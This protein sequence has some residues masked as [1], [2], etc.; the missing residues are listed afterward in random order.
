VMSDGSLSRVLLNVCSAKGRHTPQTGEP[1]RSQPRSCCPEHRGGRGAGPVRIEDGAVSRSCSDDAVGGR[2]RRPDRFCVR[3]RV[4]PE[5]PCTGSALPVPRVR[6]GLGGTAGAAP[7]T[8]RARR[9]PRSGRRTPGRA[10]RRSACAVWMHGEGASGPVPR[11]R[12]LVTAIIVRA[13]LAAASALPPAGQAAGAA[14]RPQGVRTTAPGPA[15][16]ASGRRSLRGGRSGGMARLRVAP[17]WP[18]RQALAVRGAARQRRSS[19][20]T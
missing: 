10:S 11:M 16:P 1:L 13:G 6:R 3:R 20:F 2:L 19:V 7:S 8:P 12:R 5:D 17:C 18:H 4:Q 15:G 9:P 14:R